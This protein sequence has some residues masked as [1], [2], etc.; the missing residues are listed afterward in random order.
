M[1]P[2]EECICYGNCTVLKLSLVAQWIGC[3]IPDVSGTIVAILANE[4]TV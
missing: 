1:P 4:K 3:N 2:A